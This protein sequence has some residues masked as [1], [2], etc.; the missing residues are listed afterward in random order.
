MKAR[1][2]DPAF[3]AAQRANLARGRAQRWVAP[4][5]TSPP[6]SV[7]LVLPKSISAQAVG[8][9]ADK[10]AVMVAAVLLA[11][12]VLIIVIALASAKRDA[13]EPRRQ[14]H[15]LYGSYYPNPF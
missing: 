4:L 10:S 8:A 9:G 7:A 15:P 12:T 3:A 13:S 11:V 2:R 5:G 1:W 6:T 14:S